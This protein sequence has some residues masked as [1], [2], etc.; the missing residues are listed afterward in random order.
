MSAEGIGKSD[1]SGY[2]DLEFRHE[3]IA[4]AGKNRSEIGKS[5]AHSI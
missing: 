2:Y 1:A 3:A 4:D 5:D